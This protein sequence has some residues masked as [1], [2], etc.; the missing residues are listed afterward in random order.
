MSTTTAQHGYVGMLG[1]PHP[2][3]TVS[4]DVEPRI[5]LVACATDF[6]S[7]SLH[8][9]QRYLMP[10]FSY[11]FQIESGIHFWLASTWQDGH[12]RIAPLS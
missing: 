11:S 3:K 1:L 4:F 2:S 7:V 12:S 10:F 6:L 8:W 9:W 5:V